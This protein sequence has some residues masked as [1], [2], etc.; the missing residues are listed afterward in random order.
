MGSRYLRLIGPKRRAHTWV[1]FGPT[2]WKLSKNKPTLW[3]DLGG[4]EVK[5]QLFSF[6]AD[7]RTRMKPFGYGL[8]DFF[9]GL[10]VTLVI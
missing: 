6:F 4:S 8:I 1:E 2:G 10:Y 9:V 7:H 5:I 3:L